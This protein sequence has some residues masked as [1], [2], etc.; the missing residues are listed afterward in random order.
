M[1]DHDSTAPPANNVLQGPWG[2]PAPG[3]E[4]ATPDI[5]IVKACALIADGI[6]RRW[7]TSV[8]IRFETPHRTFR[9]DAKSLKPARR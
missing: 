5:E 8:E 3:I 9:L 2:R 4:L 1:A 7:L 6:A